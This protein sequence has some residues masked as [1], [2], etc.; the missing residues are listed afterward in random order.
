AKEPADL[1]GSLPIE[2]PKEIFAERKRKE[3]TDDLID[4][5]HRHPILQTELGWTDAKARTTVDAIVKRMKPLLPPTIVNRPGNPLGQ[6]DDDEAVEVETETEVQ[7]QQ[8][9]E[10]EAVRKKVKLGNAQSDTRFDN[11]DDPQLLK[12]GGY[13]DLALYMRAKPE[14]Q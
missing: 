13:F 5:I 2:E 12:N 6:R 14:L 7:T 1:Y 10:V 11:I 4:L 9:Q 8:H 3:V